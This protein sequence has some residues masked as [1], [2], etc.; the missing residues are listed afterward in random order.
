LLVASRERSQDVSKLVKTLDAQ[1]R[2][3]LL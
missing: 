1:K 3:D 2:E